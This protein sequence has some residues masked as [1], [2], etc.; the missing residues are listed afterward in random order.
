MFTTSAG[1]AWNNMAVTPV[2]PMLLQQMVTYLTAREFETPRIVGDSLSL[3]Y[4]DQPDATDAVFDTP[5]GETVSV[6]V[7]DYR[8][9][10]VALLDGAREAGFYMAR[11]SLQAAGMP[12]AV[13]VDTK[14]S[15]VKSMSHQEV[16][17]SL[18]GTGVKVVRSQEGIL[19][20]S[21]EARTSRSFWRLFML[22]GLA[23][24][25]IESIFAHW[26]GMRAAKAGEA[27]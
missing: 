16:A 18:E 13:N 5:S 9:Q 27:G 20:A 11:V 8:N 24:F 22:A 4:V 17:T 3:S 2:F 21:E 10:Y 26:L 12:V 7:R 15:T 14:E 25:V 6:P 1:R 23:F 19:A